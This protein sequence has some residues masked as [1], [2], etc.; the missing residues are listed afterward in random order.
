MKATQLCRALIAVSI[1][2]SAS[3]ACADMKVKIGQ[4]SPLTGELAHIGKDDENGVLLAIEDLNSKKLVIGGQPVTFELDSQDDAADPKTAVTVAQKLIDDRVAGVVGH[5][6]SG[7]S[8]PASRIYAS[9]AIPMITESA[10]NPLLTQQ[11]LKSVFRMVANDARQGSVIGNYLVRGLKAT[12]VAIV[13]DRTAYGQG[14]A[15]EIEKAVKS[16]G[17]TVVE[18]EFGTDK[19]TN[20]MAVLTTIKNRRPDA[21]AFTGGD[22]Q[23]AAFVQ[24]MRRL[25]MTAKFIAGDEACTPQFIKLGGSSMTTDM[26][27]TLAGVPPS[28]MPQGPAFFKRFEERFK[29]PVQLYAPY[30]Y[31]AVMTMVAAMQAANSTDPKIYLPK[32]RAVKLDGVTGPIQFDEAGD[33]R[34]GA[35]TVRQFGSNAWNDKSVVR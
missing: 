20:W 24:Q 14:L 25:G 30:A 35:I 10:T 11:G 4:V 17:G 21:I 13:D 23:A 2:A 6:N 29:T 32:L 33:I 9:A 22:T 26:Y 15:D 19:T 5:A 18:R 28:Q 12:K 8:I 34:N 1:G 31:D 27:C 16:A 7:T 3:V